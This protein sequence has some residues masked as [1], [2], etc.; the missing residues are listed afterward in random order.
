MPFYQ[1]FCESNGKIVEVRHAMDIRL[2]TWAGVC[3]LARMEPG[4][5]P[6]D[7]PVQRLVSPAT[8]VVPKFQGLDKDY[9]GQWL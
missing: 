5:T 7:A 9:S 8:P 6:G 3:L 4:D 2:H 1:Y